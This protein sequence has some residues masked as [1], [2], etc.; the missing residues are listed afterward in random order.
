MNRTCTK[1]NRKPGQQYVEVS[2]RKCSPEVAS[3][4]VA[5]QEREVETWSGS[6]QIPSELEHRRRSVFLAKDNHQRPSTIVN[7]LTAGLITVGS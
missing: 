2:Y 5:S 6:D 7:S 4:E 1:V 3:P